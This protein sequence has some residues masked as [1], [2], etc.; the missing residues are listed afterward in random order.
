MQLESQLEKPAVR[1][2][3]YACTYWKPFVSTVVLD[4]PGEVG[5]CFVLMCKPS[6]YYCYSTL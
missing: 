4:I 5:F 1:K 2:K 3:S 6:V